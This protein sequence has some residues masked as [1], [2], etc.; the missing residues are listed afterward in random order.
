MKFT[1]EILSDFAPFRAGAIKSGD[2]MKQQKSGGKKIL[3][4]SFPVPQ[5]RE[6]KNSA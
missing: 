3:F 4:F 2:T 6:E 1:T 5:R